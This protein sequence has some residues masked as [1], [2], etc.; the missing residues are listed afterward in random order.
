MAS[1]FN[2]YWKIYAYP[3]STFHK[4]VYLYTVVEQ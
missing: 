4:A 1:V 2:V 3:T